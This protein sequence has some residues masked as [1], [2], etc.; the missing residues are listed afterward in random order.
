MSSHDDL[1]LWAGGAVRPIQ[2]QLEGRT[3][4]VAAGA[5]QFST[6][7]SRG[8]GASAL[9]LVWCLRKGLQRRKRREVEGPG[10]PVLTFPHQRRKYLCASCESC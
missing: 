8:W 6:V 4:L 9:G 1:S 7:D 10:L 2:A 5:P 3:V